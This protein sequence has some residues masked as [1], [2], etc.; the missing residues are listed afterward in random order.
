MDN[1]ERANRELETFR[2]QYKDSELLVLASDL[3]M[4]TKQQNQKSKPNQ[5]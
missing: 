5:S 4:Q 3:V 2:S 1:T